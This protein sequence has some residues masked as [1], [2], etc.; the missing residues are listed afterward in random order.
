ME[1]MSIKTNDCITSASREAL[2]Q[3]ESRL[4]LLAVLFGAVS[5]NL[6]LGRNECDAL[7]E[8]LLDASTAISTFTCNAT[9]WPEGVG[10]E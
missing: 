8:L 10:H 9:I 5:S 3:Q 6:E 1:M 7:S 4:S 2:V